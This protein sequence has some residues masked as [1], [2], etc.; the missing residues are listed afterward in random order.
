MNGK[1]LERDLADVFIR[2]V[3]AEYRL[4]L[5]WVC[6]PDESNRNTPAPDCLYSDPEAPVDVVMEVTRLYDEDR[7]EADRH[8][9]RLCCRLKELLTPCVPNGDYYLMITGNARAL[10][11]KCG[12]VAARLAK[13]RNTEGC[14]LTCFFGGR[15][16]ARR[17]GVLVEGVSVW[18]SM[19]EPAGSFD[20]KYVEHLRD[21]NR[22]LS[23]WRARGYET[24]FLYDARLVDAVGSDV[25]EPFTHAHKYA[26]GKRNA[27]TWTPNSLCPLVYADFSEIDH[28][29]VFDLMSAG[30]GAT[31][32]W[33]H[34]PPCGLTRAA[35]PNSWIIP[36]DQE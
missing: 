32:L 11:D 1:A 26:Y 21:A 12:E 24:C 25:V 29:I 17:S 31:S 33:K 7:Q 20:R 18:H 2:F 9:Q 15:V 34:E 22:K 30:V 14:D 16:V 4:C 19:P 36:W 6:A 35:F 23:G 27:P 28:V 13:L 8:W 5:A 10:M 3:N